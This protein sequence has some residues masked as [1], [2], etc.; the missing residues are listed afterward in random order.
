[1][2]FIVTI[3]V[4][5]RIS[6]KGDMKYCIVKLLEQL[7]QSVRRSWS[8]T[9]APGCSCGHASHLSLGVLSHQGPFLTALLVQLA[10]GHRQVVHTHTFQ[11][12]HGVRKGMLVLEEK[13]LPDN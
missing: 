12:R 9:Q 11:E 6:S 3:N 2:L 8:L 13:E 1:M 4:E 7:T 5:Y 10:P